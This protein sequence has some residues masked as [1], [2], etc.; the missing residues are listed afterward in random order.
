MKT[1]KS[2]T[3]LI[4]GASRGIGAAMAR[5]LADPSVTLLL[6]A[7]SEGDLRALAGEL[8]KHGARVRVFPADLSQPGAARSLHQRV[9]KAGYTAEI[10]INNAGFGKLGR[11]EDA[12]PETVEAMLSLNV[13][14]LAV[15]TRLCLPAMLHRGDGAILNV[16]SSAAYQPL[17]YFAAY[18]A[19]KSFVLS[20]SEALYGEYAHRGLTVTCL[21]PGTTATGF[22][23]RAGIDPSILPSME[24]PEK[25]A[26]VGLRAVLDGRMSVISGRG[27]AIGALLGR[28]LPSRGVVAVMRRV[29]EA[30]LDEDSDSS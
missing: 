21:S 5:H 18:A 13:T 20:F 28:L 22:Q 7:R 8:E 17:P 3:V 6:T 24:T 9:T 4:T 12:S 23:K 26:R 30:V 10:L 29:F 16:A 15:L 19:S 2:K 27:N 1:F 11:F 14:N 25:V